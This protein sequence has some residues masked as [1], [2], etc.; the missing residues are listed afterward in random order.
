MN[1]PVL[2][3]AKFIPDPFGVDP[4]ARLYATGDMGRYLPDG[5][6][7]FRGRSDDQVKVRG[8]RIEPGEVEAALNTHEGVRESVVV[9]REDTPGE[10]R[11]VAYVVAGDV[12]GNGSEL[13]T[14]LVS[15]LKGRLPEYLVPS[16]I[17]LLEAMPLTPNGK[18]DR[19]ALPNP[20]RDVGDVNGAFIAPRTPVEEVVAEIWNDVL[21]SKGKLSIHDSFFRVGGHSLLA[22]QVISRVRDA[23]HVE[24][25][26]RSLF[27]S[28]TIAEFSRLV[29]D[30]LIDELEEMTEEEARAV[31][32]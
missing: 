16:Q 3:A 26:L 15:H 1:Y 25:P 2:T 18:V 7:D 28:P 8:F 23:L 5:Q 32:V 20:E 17:M 29:E 14:T 27:D 22:T 4:G 19:K 30:K 31:N 10:K 6:I 21:G 11:L 12:T 24:L 9:A 13:V